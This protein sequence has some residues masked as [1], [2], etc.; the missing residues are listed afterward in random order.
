MGTEQRESGEQHDTDVKRVGW[1]N[2]WFLC[3]VH[4]C[5]SGRQHGSKNSIN[6]VF[7]ATVQGGG[8]GSLNC[9]PVW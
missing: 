3:D 9:H 4:E 7:P 8:G 5:P 1:T 2:D 6:H